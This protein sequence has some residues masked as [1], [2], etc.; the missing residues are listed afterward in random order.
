M[1]GLPLAI[2]LMIEESLDD[3]KAHF[4]N[5]KVTLLV[6]NPDIAGHEGDV[7][8]TQ[9]TFSA[10]YCALAYLETKDDA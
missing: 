6:R 3:I 1:A 9:D 4:K 5:A 8:L 7:I 10:I 2:R